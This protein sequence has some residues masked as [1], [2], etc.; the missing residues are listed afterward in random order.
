M[1]PS[2]VRLAPGAV[3]VLDGADISIQGPLEVCSMGVR[4]EAIGPCLQ[5]WPQA[6]HWFAGLMG[7]G[8][9]CGRQ[10]MSH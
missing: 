2:S 7:Q 1:A 6:L 4:Q 8:I 3:L 10:D 9:A 5:P